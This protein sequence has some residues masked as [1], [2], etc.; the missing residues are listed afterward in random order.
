MITGSPVKQLL[1]C[2][3]G[4]AGQNCMLGRMFD[5]CEI[6]SCQYVLIDQLLGPA[7]TKTYHSDVTEQHGAL[8]VDAQRLLEVDF[9]QVELLL[10]VVNHPKAIPRHTHT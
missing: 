9:C 10:L 3:M 2:I 4:L 5:T 1:H 8:R 7:E 6:N